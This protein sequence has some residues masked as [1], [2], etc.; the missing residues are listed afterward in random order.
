YSTVVLMTLVIVI[1]LI[2]FLD[3]GFSFVARFLFK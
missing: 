1:I 3:Y 2:F